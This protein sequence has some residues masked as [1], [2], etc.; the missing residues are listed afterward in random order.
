LADT[1]RALGALAVAMLA[2]SLP[3]C[4]SPVPLD[5]RPQADLDPRL[6][7]AWRC[8]PPA[9]APDDEPANLTIASGVD[10]VY[11]VEFGEAGKDKDRYEAH[12]STVGERTVVNVRDLSG[13]DEPWDFLDYEF[14]RPNILLIRIAGEDAFKGVALTP[15]T[16]R[17]RMG[18]PGAFTDFAVCVPQKKG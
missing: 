9:A 4:L 11:A 3:A 12:A 6:V 16:L 18:K 17:E 14:V 10:R 1:R 5:P 7:G 2:L 13:G 15:A 8:L